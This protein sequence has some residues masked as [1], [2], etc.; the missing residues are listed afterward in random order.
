MSMWAVAGHPLLVATEVRNLT[1]GQREVL[2]NKEVLEV[3]QQRAVRASESV[4]E[5]PQLRGEALQL[6]SVHSAGQHALH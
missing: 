5:Q 2:L 1:A 6:R 4:R 3:N